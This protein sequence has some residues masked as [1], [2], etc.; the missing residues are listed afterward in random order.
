MNCQLQNCLKLGGCSLFEN[1]HGFD[2]SQMNLPMTDSDRQQWVKSMFQT[3]EE[4]EM[5]LPLLKDVIFNIFTDPNEKKIF[6]KALLSMKRDYPQLT[7]RSSDTLTVFPEWFQFDSR[8][9]KKQTVV[10]PVLENI[11]KEMDKTHSDFN[12]ID[13]F[14]RKI[15]PQLSEQEV[16]EPLVRFFFNQRGV[17]LHSLKFHQYMRPFTNLAKDSCQGRISSKH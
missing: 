17:L 6:K 3:P 10:L 8:I 4:Q 1:R 16:F 2:A 7:E 9:K 13:Q 15:K 14:I 11:K 5:F 12:K